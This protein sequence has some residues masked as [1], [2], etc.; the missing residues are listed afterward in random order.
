RGRRGTSRPARRPA[1]HT[2][3]RGVGGAVRVHADVRSDSLTRGVKAVAFVP[4][5]MIAIAGWSHRWMN[6]DAY[7]N[8]RV[9]DQVFAGHGPVFNA[10]ERIEAATSPLWLGV[11]VMG[12][13]LFGLFVRD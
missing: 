8:L 9:L 2:D 12:R 10:G 11:L 6:E 1:L 3:G 7:I 4:A 13:F 5:V